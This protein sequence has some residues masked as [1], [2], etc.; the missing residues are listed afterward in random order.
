MKINAFNCTFL[1]IF[2]EVFNRWN[3]NNRTGM[4]ESFKLELI[5]I[6]KS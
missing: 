5:F 6:K 3:A 1:K 4:G 2:Y